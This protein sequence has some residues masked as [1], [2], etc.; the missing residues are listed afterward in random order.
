M[1]T[2]ASTDFDTQ[3]LR[4]WTEPDRARRGEI[5]DRLWS[6]SGRL[7]VSSLGV[8]IE[9][10]EQI[11]AHIA[12]VHDELIAGKGLVFSY[13]QHVESGGALLLRWSMTAPGGEVVGRGADVIFRGED[14]LISSVHMF[15]GV[16]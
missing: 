6:P 4:T 8:T 5:I 3:Y 1:S 13:D 10:V 11:A 16:N 2:G 9:G 7:S 14:G 12:G 15:M